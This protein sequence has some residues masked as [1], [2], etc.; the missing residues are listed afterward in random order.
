MNYLSIYNSIMQQARNR[1][2]SHGFERHHVIP[3]SLGGANNLS[4]LVQLTLREHF[5]AHKL[6]TRIHT[7]SAQKKMWFA[8]YRL[9]NRHQNT[10]SRLY[11]QAKL[12]SKK[13][14]SEIHAGKTISNAHKTRLSN[15]F[16]GSGNPN[17]NKKHTDQAL[18]FMSSVKVGNTNA[19]VGVNIVDFQ[20]NALIESVNSIADLCKKFDLTRG[21]AEHYIYKQTPY[22]GMLFVRQKIIKRK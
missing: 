4:N 19:R 9:C 8:Y 6:L 3:K 14:L 5:V 17:Y 15:L 13:Y 10:N 12:Q 22:N 11:K 16:T 18:E 2:L 7:G 21:Q 20:T 1:T